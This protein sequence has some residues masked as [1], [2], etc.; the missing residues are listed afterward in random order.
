MAWPVRTGL[1]TGPKCPRPICTCHSR[2]STVVTPSTGGSIRVLHVDDE[3]SI[4]ELTAEMLERADDRFEV[5]T[6]TSAEDGLAYLDASPVDCVVSDYEM[7]EVNG[8]GFLDAVREN[9]PDLP[10]I[11][12]TGKGS[13]EVASQA[14]ARGVTFYQQKETSIEQYELLANNVR[15]AVEGRRAV[16]EADRQRQE[17]RQYER[18]VE[19]S[20]DLVA[21]V[22]VD[23]RIEFANET[24][25]DYH[26]RDRDEVVGTHLKELI[27]ETAHE[28]V[29]PHLD[30]ALAGEASQIEVTYDF[31]DRGKRDLDVRY[32]PLS[33]G[34]GGV[35]GAVAH[36]R[37]VTEREARERD[38]Q[39]FES[40]VQHT[41]D[42]IFVF[43]EEARFE[44]V[45][46]RVVDVSGIDREHWLGEPVSMLA[47]RGM[48]DE[49][50]VARLEDAIGMILAGEEDVV[51]FEFAPNLPADITDLESRLTP[52]SVGDEHF[53]LAFTRDV[54]DRVARTR[55]LERQHA[56]FRTVLENVPVVLFALDDDGVFTISE[57]RGL[58]ALGLEPGE[59]VGRSALE[60]YA[61]YPEVVAKLRRALAGKAVSGTVDIDD[62]TFETWFQ[63]VVAEGSIEQVIGVAMDVTDRRAYRRELERQNER[64]DAF[65][66]VVSHDLRSPLNVAQARLDLAETGDDE[67]LA[68][69]ER[70]LDR[71]EALVEDVLTLARVGDA[72]TDLE[73]ISLDAV[74]AESWELVVADAATLV[75]DSDRFVRA[76]RGMLQQ[77]LENLLGN[78]VE[79]GGPEVTVRVGGTDDGF[80]VADDG[81]GI[82]EADREQVFESGYSTEREGTGFG[83][84]IA[85]QIADAHGWDLALTDSW[86][87]GARFVVTGVDGVD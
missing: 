1:L 51:R 80:F 34:D 57:G 13:E 64:L 53:V 49:K 86:A 41:E 23:S 60:M 47:D 78:A 76:D 73:P 39:L 27:G 19:S 26:D 24:L 63:P 33:D 36:L 32:Y 16:A 38:R 54:S 67:H 18:A 84:H 2:D 20:D 9:Y 66:S 50:A 62:R 31:A 75:V 14:I 10:F 82:P 79:H 11:L 46:E 42:G 30:R 55:G 44:F 12:F 83:L 72:A 35:E 37:D 70:S 17:L 6:A 4:T 7:P 43:D 52:L 40:I 21:A 45:N 61:D 69:V 29:A 22:D 68:A 15:Q 74:T 81:P 28:Q 77:L 8:L 58:D 87:G 65:A 3:P 5:A 85:A 59:A 48:L 56:R 71:M 25:L